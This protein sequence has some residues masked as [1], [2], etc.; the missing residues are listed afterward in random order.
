MKRGTFNRVSL[1]I[2]LQ[3]LTVIAR[4]YI[5]PLPQLT[6]AAEI[7][8]MIRWRTV[9]YPGPSS[10]HIQMENKFEESI[11][12]AE[13]LHRPQISCLPATHP[14]STILPDK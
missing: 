2:E 10:K 8:F 14:A 6:L 9:N 3:I 4:T 12:L 11:L 1:N 5:C 7:I 13:Q